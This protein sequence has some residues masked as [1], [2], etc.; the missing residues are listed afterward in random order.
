MS[1]DVSVSNSSPDTFIIVYIFTNMHG[2]N[3]CHL[4]LL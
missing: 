1:D 4:D 3:V 2:K